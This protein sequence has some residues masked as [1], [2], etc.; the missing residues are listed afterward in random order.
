MSADA[1]LKLHAGRR[2]QFIHKI[3]ESTLGLPTDFWIAAGRNYRPLESMDYSLSLRGRTNLFNLSYDISAYYR[4]FSHMMT[5]NGSLFDMLGNRFDPMSG[6]ESGGAGR[7]VLPQWC[8][9]AWVPCR[10]F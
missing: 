1:S 8:R 7:M 3:E 6:V 2:A 9:G 4:T 10:A 5:W